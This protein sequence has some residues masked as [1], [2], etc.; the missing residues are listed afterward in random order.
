MKSKNLRALLAVAAL[1]VPAAHAA[2]PPEYYQAAREQAPHHLQLRVEQV[3]L[4]R[5]QVLGN[6][7]IQATVLRDFRGTLEKGTPLRFALNCTAPG[8]RPMPGPNAWHDY[9][10]LEATRFAEGFFR[11]TDTGTG[12][13]PVYGQL[14][15]VADEREWPWC[16]ADSGRCDLPPP[17]PPQVL[18]C[19]T[20]GL[21]GTG[22]QTRSGWII[23]IA[24]HRM[25]FWSDIKHLYAGGDRHWQLHLWEPQRTPPP[26]QVDGDRYTQ[27]SHLYTEGGEM[28]LMTRTFRYERSTGEFEERH[29]VHENGGED[30]TRGTCQP[31]A[32]PETVPA[33]G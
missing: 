10:T 15:A 16:E 20:V 1:G 6:C 26:L 9:G 28:L 14:D 19:S 8:V 24:N 31:I 21:G 27:V 5:G 18:E 32:D 22:R 4:L 29:V 7:E 13:V 17:E 12:M 25:W 2:L 23:K 30:L 33:P 3:V 11:G